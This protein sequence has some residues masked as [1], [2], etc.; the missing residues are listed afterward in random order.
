MSGV[1]SSSPRAFSDLTIAVPNRGDDVSKPDVS[2][3][4]HRGWILGSVAEHTTSGNVATGNKRCRPAHSPREHPAGNNVADSRG[5]N[6]QGVNGSTSPMNV[7]DENLTDNRGKSDPVDKSQLP[8]EPPRTMRHKRPRSLDEGPTQNRS[9]HDK[10]SLPPVLSRTMQSDQPE[11]RDGGHY[12]VVLGE[13]FKRPG[14]HGSGGAVD[15]SSNAG[16]CVHFKYDFI[17]GRTDVDATAML[18]QRPLGGDEAE[19]IARTGG[20]N[21]GLRWTAEMKYRSRHTENPGPVHF[22]GHA[23]R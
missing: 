14:N 10:G 6:D 8:P 16:H 7:K 1:R 9:T 23:S 2:A 18:T 3:T 15:E 13:S 11:W 4:E 22:S 21:E 5:A 20:T 17:P 19:N 12:K